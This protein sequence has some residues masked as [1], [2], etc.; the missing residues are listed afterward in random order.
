M[1]TTASK[2]QLTMTTPELSL[3]V[4][5]MNEE[6]NIQ[7]FYD[8]TEAVLSKL[9]LSYEILFVDDGSTDNTVDKMEKLAEIN[10]SIRVLEF[11]RNFGKEAA[12]S[13]GLDHASGQAVIMIDSDLQHP[14]EFIEELVAAWKDGGEVVYGV[15]KD[16]DDDGFLRRSFTVTFYW[17]LSKMGEV[18]VPSNAGD[19]R[20]LDRAAVDALCNLGERNRFMKGL[21]AWVG[22]RT[23]AL[24]FAVETRKHGKSS[25]SLARLFNFALDGLTSFS[26]I[27]LRVSGYAG[28]IVAGIA[29]VYGGIELINALLFER[30]TPGFASLIV[31]I[32][33]LGGVQMMFLGVIGEYLGRVYTEVKQRPVYLLRDRQNT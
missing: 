18:P 17:L 32:L 20:L 9:G 13:A 3:I 31:A 6:Q 30:T 33:F 10:D 24:P 8:R 19:Y 16:R 26:N 25:F 29:L 11:S 15:R 7:E 4:P 2:D 22:F 12:L 1:K 27:P 14:P 23:V 28:F 5:C 21:Y